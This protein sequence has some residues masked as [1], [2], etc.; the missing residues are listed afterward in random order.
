MNVYL[1]W[2]AFR[3]YF[4]V[5]WDRK[6][7]HRYHLNHGVFYLYDPDGTTH[8]VNLDYGCSIDFGSLG[9][10]FSERRMKDGKI[11]EACFTRNEIFA[12][13]VPKNS[14]YDESNTANIFIPSSAVGLVVGD[15]YE[16]DGEYHISTYRKLKFEITYFGT[17]QDQPHD[18]MLVS[19]ENGKTY[20][21]V[22]EYITMRESDEYLNR[23]K[24]A[25]QIKKTCGVEIGDYDLK[26]LLTHYKLTK[27]RKQDIKSV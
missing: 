6:K 1:F 13:R 19:D 8:K 11:P 27:K 26:R 14:R 4:C 22:E 20:L 25:K 5:I 21:S 9:L 15:N 16:V 3:G 10:P 18:N 17:F 7:S 23:Q 12:I 24:I 2:E